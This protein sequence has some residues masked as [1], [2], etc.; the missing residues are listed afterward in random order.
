MSV[1]KPPLAAQPIEARLNTTI[2]ATNRPRIES[3]RV[4]SPVRG[5]AITSA[6]R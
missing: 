6:M 2:A 1:A 3:T 4:S 5:I